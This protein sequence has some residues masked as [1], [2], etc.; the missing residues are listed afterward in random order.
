MTL[1]PLLPLGELDQLA[2]E[3]GTDKSSRTHDYMRLY[4]F[5][6]KPFKDQDFCF[7]ELGV[8][9]PRIQAASL[10]SWRRFFTKALIVGVDN[11]RRVRKFSGDDFTIRIGDASD[12]AFLTKMSETYK[13]SIVL[14]DASHK[15]SHQIIAFKTMFP[16]LPPGGLYVI[17]DIFTSFPMPIKYDVY[18]D[19][20]ESCW[21][22]ISRL[23]AALAG[24]QTEWPALSAEESELVSWIDAVFL[25]RR[26]VIFVKRDAQ[27]PEEV[28]RVAELK[29]RQ[30]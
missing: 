11:D 13:P 18:A 25:T 21:T 6:F 5:L 24:C 4:E 16:L 8:G 3:M 7:M 30:G 10:R 22:F 1:P 26:T 14:D 28:E 15:W 12:P 29:R 19:H 27:R 9:L 20:P 2:Q 23:Q 17:E